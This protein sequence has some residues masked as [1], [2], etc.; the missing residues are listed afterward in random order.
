MKNEARNV[1]SETERLNRNLNE[2]QLKFQNLEFSSRKSANDCELWQRRLNE[3]V[4]ESK[5]EI[6]EI[7]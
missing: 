7:K 5:L 2:I 1:K 4:A 6:L 3:S